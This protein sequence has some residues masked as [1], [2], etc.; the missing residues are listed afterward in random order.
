VP[1][2]STYD[3]GKED[4]HVSRGGHNWK[5][6]R[7]VEEVRSLD[8]RKLARAA[9]LA[10]SKIGTWQWSYRDGSMASVLIKGG[11]DTITLNY[12]SNSGRE[13][14][15]HVS[16]H[17]PIKWTLCGFGGERPWFVCDVHANGVYC[18]RRVAKLYGGGRLFACRHCYRLGYAI[19]RSGSIDRAHHNLARLHHK[20]RANYDG[21]DIPPPQKPKWMR[22][23]TYSRIAQQIEAGQER[24]DVVFTAGA[25]RILS[26]LERAE[27]QSRSRRWTQ[28]LRRLR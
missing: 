15:Q 17:I 20:L 27:H 21:P 26:R 8:V 16:Q 9:Y 3:L 11:R 4:E 23:N 10:G 18:G 14:W 19:Q 12:R 2:D 5:G 24:L 25:Q 7:T 6:G 13:D 1:Q 28:D 22:W